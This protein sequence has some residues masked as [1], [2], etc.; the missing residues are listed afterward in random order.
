MT[1]E[2]T[3]PDYPDPLASLSLLLSRSEARQWPYDSDCEIV[4]SLALLDDT[5]TPPDLRLRI[6]IACG[7]LVA[8]RFNRRSPAAS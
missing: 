4:D 7:R 5:W 3:N 6:R 2:I 1:D 8:L